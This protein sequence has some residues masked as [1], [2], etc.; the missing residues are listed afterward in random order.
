MSDGKRRSMVPL[1]THQVLATFHAKRFPHAM[2]AWEIPLLR[3][4][5]FKSASFDVCPS[6]KWIS[7]EIVYSF[8]ML[9]QRYIKIF[10]NQRNRP[11]NRRTRKWLRR[12]QN[13][14]SR[15]PGANLGVPRTATIGI[16]AEKAPAVRLFG[17]KPCQQKNTPRKEE[18]LQV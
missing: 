3:C 7:H 2:Q 11:P 14:I 18:C 1:L 5:K 16:G 8:C 17:E 6:T 4:V 15:A 13:E 12:R 10:S 9:L